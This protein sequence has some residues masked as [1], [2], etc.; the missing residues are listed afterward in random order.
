MKIQYVISDTFY[1]HSV[2]IFCRQQIFNGNLH[3]LYY[4]HVG[5]KREIRFSESL[6][7]L[8]SVQTYSLPF[9]CFA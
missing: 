1:I 5:N 7:L 2:Y 9:L 4:I 8:T 6:F 3:L